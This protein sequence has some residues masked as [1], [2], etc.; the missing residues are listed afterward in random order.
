M[1]LGYPKMQVVPGRW[2]FPKSETVNNAGFAAIDFRSPSYFGAGVG[3][4]A[5]QA[6]EAGT[7]GVLKG[8]T[9]RMLST[10]AASS[11]SVAFSDTPGAFYVTFD[12]SLALDLQFPKETDLSSLYLD[13]G[14][15]DADIEMLVYYDLGTE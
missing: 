15:L 6:A 1:S 5:A 4:T 7:S 14:G 11:V 12:T 10:S 8:I 2:F 9:L 3:M 13:T